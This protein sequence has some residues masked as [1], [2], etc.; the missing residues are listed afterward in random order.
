MLV[1]QPNLNIFFTGYQSTYWEAYKLAESKHERIATTYPV[2][3]EIWLQGFLTMVQKYREWIGNRANNAP[4]PLTYQVP[5]KLFENTQVIDQFK[6]EDDTHGIYAPTVPFM[7]MQA[8]KWPDYQIRDLI[9]NQGSWT[10][11]FQNCLDGLTFWNTAHPVN[12]WDPAQGTFANDYTGGGV[13]VNNQSIGGGIS[14]TSFAT[15]YEDMTRRK[16]ESGEAWGLTP[17][18]SMSG[19]IMKLAMDTVLQAQFIGA[20]Q[21]GQL[22]SGSGANAA[23]VGST[24][25]M[26]RAWTDHFMWE[27]LSS[28]TVVGTSP[29][30]YD[31]VFYLLSTNG[32]IKPFA[33]LLRQAPDFTFRINLQDPLVYEKHQF[34]F[35]SVARG[36]AAFGFPA[37]ASRSG[38]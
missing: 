13:T 37:L 19:P 3:T 6:F 28:S 12:Y 5:I 26:A 29:N 7:G 15:V 9:L 25:N 32:P 30:T 33:W 8:K 34:S 31:Q 21:I 16:N 20:P 10:G 38:P 17:N 23:F 27:D 22:G 36:S 35:G 18:L 24:S 1:T 4:A 14:L 11:S 2:T